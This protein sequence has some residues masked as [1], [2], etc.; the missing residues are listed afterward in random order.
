MPSQTA[1]TTASTAAPGGPQPQPNPIVSF[2]PIIVIC[3][4]L[5]MLVIRPQQK[6]AKDHRRMV[7]NLKPGDRI[8]TQG[9]LL[10]NVV[11]LKPASVVIRVPPDNTKLEVSR[12]AISQ[13]L[14]ETTNGASSPKEVV[15]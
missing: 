15:S 12:S 7:D 11:S 3:G 5:Y 1:T 8:V 14:A 2:V 4:I 9:G 10:G 13:V 6:Q